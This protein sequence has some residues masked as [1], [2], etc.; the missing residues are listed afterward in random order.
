MRPSVSAIACRRP[1]MTA[2]GAI[3]RSNS[4]LAHRPRPPRVG[5]VWA[6][7]PGG[8]RRRG[9]LLLQKR[10]RQFLTPQRIFAVFLFAS[11]C[12]IG[13]PHSHFTSVCPFIVS[14]F[15]MTLT[16]SS[17]SFWSR[18]IAARLIPSAG[19]AFPD[20]RISSGIHHASSSVTGTPRASPNRGQVVALPAVAAQVRHRRGII[21]VRAPG[22]DQALIRC[23]QGRRDQSP[24]AQDAARPACLSPSRCRGSHSSES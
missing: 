22:D 23:T 17:P 4:F 8:W 11:C 18:F 1:V 9:A 20:T 14:P 15:S 12:P 5:V 3:S 2:S 24:A 21:D 16:L 13:C 6:T 7:A 10:Q 19:A